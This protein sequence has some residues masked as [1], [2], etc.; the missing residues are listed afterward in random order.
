MFCA[1]REGIL[2]VIIFYLSTLLVAASII[3]IIIIIIT[4]TTRLFL[5]C[6]YSV[7]FITLYGTINDSCHYLLAIVLLVL[8]SISK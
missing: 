6:L 1:Y 7:Y 4:V 5:S 3:I 2:S 8:L